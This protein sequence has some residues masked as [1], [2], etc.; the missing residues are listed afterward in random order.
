MEAAIQYQSLLFQEM[1]RQGAF[2]EANPKMMALYFYAPI[3]FC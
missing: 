3:F 1:I 2:E